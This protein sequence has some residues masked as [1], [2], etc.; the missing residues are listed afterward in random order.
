MYI[1]T[2]K[3]YFNFC[4]IKKNGIMFSKYF[5]SQVLFN[6]FDDIIPREIKKPKKEKPEE[7]VKK[8]K[9]KGTK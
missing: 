9:P 1:N 7:E 6:P 5:F 4:E 8:L 3:Y 2:T